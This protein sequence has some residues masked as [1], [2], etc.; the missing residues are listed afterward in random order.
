MWRLQ[1]DSSELSLVYD[2]AEH[3]EPIL[4]G[5]DN[6]EVTPDGELLV[7]E[8]AGDMQ[9]V[10]LDKQYRAVPLVTLHGHDGSEIAGP[11]FSPDGRRLYFSSQRGILGGA[12]GGLTY[13][14][15]IPA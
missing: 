7:A 5:V 6:I 2:A 15:T 3:D 9:I 13:E 1:L 11:A 12:S 14:L 4:A 8:D 10:V